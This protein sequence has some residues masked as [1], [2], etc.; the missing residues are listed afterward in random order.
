MFKKSK[1]RKYG[2]KRSSFKKAVMRVVNRKAE[3]K[4][5]FQARA[6]NSPVT[7]NNVHNICSNLFDIP[8]GVYGSSVNSNYGTRVGKQIYV[9]GISIAYAIESQQY[10]MD[11]K[12]TIAV[13]AGKNTLTTGVID[14]YGEV[15]E[16]VSTRIPMDYIDMDKVKITYMK[17]MSIRM[18]AS[19]TYTMLDAHGMAPEGTEAS[20][21]VYTNPKRLGKLWVPINKVI[22]YTDQIANASTDAIPSGF[23][24]LQLVLWAYDNFSSTTNDTTY[25]VGHISLST[26]VYFTDV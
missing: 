23:D 7:H 12:Y 26:K 17:N 5:Y 8:L 18:P 25:P 4:E 1:G 13:M 19:G 24:R 11:C 6:S 21:E 22:R 3:T 15:F 10:R 2:R 9:K 14:T 20:N 16:G